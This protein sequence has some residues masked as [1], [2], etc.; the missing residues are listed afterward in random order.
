MGRQ[1]KEKALISCFVNE[2]IFLPYMKAPNCVH[3][4]G[5]PERA[6]RDPAHGC[7]RSQCLGGLQG[8]WAQPHREAET[9]VLQPT[10]HGTG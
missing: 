6:G 10:H 3:S 5:R 9:D 7:D 2:N 1:Q 4:E 8:S